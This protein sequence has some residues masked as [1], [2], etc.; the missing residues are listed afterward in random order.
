MLK[1]MTWYVYQT[2]ERKIYLHEIECNLFEI[3]GLKLSG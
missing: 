1:D 3:S 2:N